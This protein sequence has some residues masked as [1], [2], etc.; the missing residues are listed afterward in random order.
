MLNIGFKTLHL[1]KR[2]PLAISRGVITGSD[3]LFVSVSDGALT[4][5]GEMAPGSTEGAD[6]PEKGEAMLRA[7]CADGLDP[8][9]IHRSWD[10]AFAGGMAACALAAL[11]MA[12]WDL[13]AKQAGC[14]S[15]ACWALRDVP[16]D[17]AHHRHQPSRRRARAGAAAAVARRKGTQDQARFAARALT[18][19]RRCSPPTP[20]RRKVAMSF[21]SVDANGGW[22]PMMPAT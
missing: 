22:A 13:R 11:D 6:T 3:N 21:C 4:G 16:S 14:R 19:T 9:S 8:D 5:W 18:P 7:F 17:I 20:R 1:H 12:L 15:I 10:S 2:F